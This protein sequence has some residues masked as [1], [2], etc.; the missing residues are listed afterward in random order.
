MGK[1]TNCKKT[2]HPTRFEQQN[3]I[4]EYKKKQEERKRRRRIELCQKKSKK[5]EKYPLKRLKWMFEDF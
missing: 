4:E 3:K 5:N 2:W 1:N